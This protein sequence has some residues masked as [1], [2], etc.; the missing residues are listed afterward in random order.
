M[1]KLTLL[2]FF[3]L[4]MLP[5]IAGA[6]GYAYGGYR[7]AGF[8]ASSLF[9]VHNRYR[10]GHGH[11]SHFGVYLGIPLWGPSFSYYPYSSP[12]Y[13]P[14]YP[15]AVYVQPRAPDYVEKNIRYR[16]YCPD[17]DGY[18]PNVRKCDAR[19]EKEET[20]GPADGSAERDEPVQTED[21]KP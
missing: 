20:A 12:Y 21:S 13:Y 7:G 5:L 4:S 15:E 9:H 1:K 3:S 17:P 6:S 18:F 16:Y 2:A 14:E 19:W 8:Y 11:R 10:G